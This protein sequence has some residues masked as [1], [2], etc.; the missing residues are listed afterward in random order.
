[1]DNK[2]DRTF[3]EMRNL[4]ADPKYARQA[5]RSIGN[6]ILNSP[7][8]RNVA[9]FDRNGDETFESM[10]RSYSYEKLKQDVDA[11]CKAQNQPAREP[12]ELE[13]IMQCQI[14]KARTDT[15]AATFVRDTLGAKPVDETKVD[16]TLSNPYESLTDDELELIAKHREE[17]AKL[18]EQAK[19]SLPCTMLDDATLEQFEP[20]EEV[21]AN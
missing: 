9:S 7:C 4:F 13:M 10:L 11:I 6:A 5:W 18:D 21:N 14:V 19:Q 3:K 8:T 2:P 1:M 20:L 15:A 17:Q 12:T 16:A